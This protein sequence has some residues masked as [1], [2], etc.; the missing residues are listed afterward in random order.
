ML[1]KQR[2]QTLH[3]AGGLEK[4]KHTLIDDCSLG[5]MLKDHVRAAR[6]TVILANATDTHSLRGYGDWKNIR[7]MIARTAFEQLQFSYPF[8]GGCVVGLGLL[9]VWPV[10]ALLFGGMAHKFFALLTLGLM[11]YSYLPMIRY[12]GRPLFQALSLPVVAVAYVVATLHSA[13]QYA[14]GLGGSWKGRH[15]AP[16]PHA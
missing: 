10:L 12:Y 6:R 8:L 14:R 15:Y 4:I 1:L 5:Q 2:R 9:F 11:V 3:E 16:E 13:R 7:D